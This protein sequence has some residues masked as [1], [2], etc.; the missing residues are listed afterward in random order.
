ME[1]FIERENKKAVIRAITIYHLQLEVVSWFY[2]TQP[3]IA[4]G[5][6]LYLSILLYSILV[7]F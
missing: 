5:S 2:R 4:L 7:H 3:I 1:R 6:S